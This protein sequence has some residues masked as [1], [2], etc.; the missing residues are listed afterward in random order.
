MEERLANST[1][2]QSYAQMYYHDVESNMNDI[3]SQEKGSVTRAYTFRIPLM[4]DESSLT[5]KKVM[6]EKVIKYGQQS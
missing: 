3:N 6:Q 1:S 2:K 4:R 5:H